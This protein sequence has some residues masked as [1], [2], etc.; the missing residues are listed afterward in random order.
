MPKSVAGV[1]WNGA[2]QRAGSGDR[3]VAQ[4]ASNFES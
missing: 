1:G 2:T 4:R 3:F